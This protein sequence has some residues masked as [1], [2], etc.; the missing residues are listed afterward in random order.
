MNEETDT[1]PKRETP[2]TVIFSSNSGDKIRAIFFKSSDETQRVR[3]KSSENTLLSPRSQSK[4]NI[5]PG[6]VEIIE[7]LSFEQQIARF[8]NLQDADGYTLLMHAIRN[9][10]FPVFIKIL[11]NKNINLNL[12]DKEGNT[13]LHHAAFANRAEYIM[14]LLQERRLSTRKK[15]RNGVT[16]RELID[17]SPMRRLHSLI[18]MR[19]KIHE[20]KNR[21]PLVA[22][23]LDSDEENFISELPKHDPGEK[24]SEANTVLHY[25]AYLG[26]AAHVNLLLLD[27]R[28]EIDLKNMYE[29]R[30][31]ECFYSANTPDAKNVRTNFFARQM[32]DVEINKH[33]ILR[34]LNTK[35]PT[36]ESIADILGAMKDFRGDTE[37]IIPFPEC[38]SP[39]LIRD[40]INWRAAKNAPDW[41]A[42][43]VEGDLSSKSVEVSDPI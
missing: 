24:D 36:E 35:N 13:A 4:A 5:L 20:K 27:Y 14:P 40:I 2:K 39:Q 29:L 25:A 12:K 33:L 28:V 32:L 19:K 1:P 43:H 11:E 17:R 10:D 21:L 23:M 38:F 37:E 30:P 9:L 34:T 22:I 26:K 31:M 7:S 41:S 16:P 18:A 42:F 15:N 8:G 6:V 3:K